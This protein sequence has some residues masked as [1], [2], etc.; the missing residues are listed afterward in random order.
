[1]LVTHER[2]KLIQA[3]IFFARNTNKFGKIKLFKLLYFLDFEHFKQ[4]GRNVT[5]LTYNAWKMGPVPV[6]LKEEINSPKADMAAA[7]HFDTRQVR[8]GQ[9]LVIEPQVSFSDQLFSGREMTILND[10]A[11]EYRDANAEDMIEKTHLE[12]RP[13]DKIYNQQNRKQQEIPYE[14]AIRDDERET[15]LTI[16]RE[17]KEL[18]ESLSNESGFRLF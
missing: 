11:R 5:G 1:M 6:S 16:A 3:I 13:W 2:E 7:I 10:L 12:N 8:S 17:R 18:L 15:V 4:T 14:L 9:M